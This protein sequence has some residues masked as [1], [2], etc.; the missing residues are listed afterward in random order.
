MSRCSWTK[1]VRIKIADPAARHAVSCELFVL[2]RERHYPTFLV[3]DLVLTR[4]SP[5]LAVRGTATLLWAIA[6][7]GAALRAT[8][9]RELL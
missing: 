6:V 4:T 3:S 9:M 7:R 8:D 1:Q 2:L 5:F